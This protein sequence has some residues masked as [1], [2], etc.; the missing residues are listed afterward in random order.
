MHLPQAV[1]N[2]EHEQLNPIRH[3]VRITLSQVTLTKQARI[4]LGMAVR[5][6]AAEFGLDGRALAKS[7]SGEIYWRMDEDSLIFVLRSEELGADMFVQIPEDH[8]SFKN[9]NRRLH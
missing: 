7:L 5:E 1:H 3:S 8:W 2:T 4:S 6:V 9:G